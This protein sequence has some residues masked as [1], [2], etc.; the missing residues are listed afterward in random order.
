MNKMPSRTYSQITRNI[1]LKQSHLA[2]MK[3]V[4]ELSKPSSAPQDPPL[5]QG[6]LHEFSHDITQDSPQKRQ[7]NK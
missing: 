2:N 1:S 5:M 6:L 3:I 4:I 7:E